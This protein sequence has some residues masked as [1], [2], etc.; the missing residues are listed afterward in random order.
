MREWLMRLVAGR[1]AYWIAE[2]TASQFSSL[3]GVLG[4]GAVVALVHSLRQADVSRAEFQIDGWT[5][6]AI[7]KDGTQ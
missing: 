6:T 5:V 4:A 1:R 2:N 3:H 7:R